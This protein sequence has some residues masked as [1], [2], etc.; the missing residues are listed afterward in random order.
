MSNLISKQLGECYH[1]LT[2]GFD[3]ELVFNEQN[4]CNY[5]L[6]ASVES[7]Q[8]NNIERK[9]YIWKNA[10]DNYKNLE[11]FELAEKC[12]Y[13]LFTLLE[14]QFDKMN[15]TEFICYTYN[16]SKRLECLAESDDTENF[17]KH[18]CHLYGNIIHYYY[19]LY[20]AN[21][22]YVIPNS[23]NRNLKNEIISPS[24]M[25]EK[26]CFYKEYIYI[27]L[28]AAIIEIDGFEDK[29]FLLS[30]T[31][32]SDEVKSKILRRFT[33]AIHKTINPEVIEDV[34][35]IYNMISEY[36]PDYKEFSDILSEFKWFC[37]TYQYDDFEYKD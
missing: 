16:Y 28:L 12:Y 20:T 11:K 27:T 4:K 7:S 29:Q 31:D 13:E 36:L 17:Y 3:S 22:D 19:D 26:S 21:N 5:Y 24:F 37:E 34:F 25:L 30:V 1:D 15:D 14:T 33:N 10:A 6:I 2:V 8:T 9:K 32:F 35:D 18:F 23:L